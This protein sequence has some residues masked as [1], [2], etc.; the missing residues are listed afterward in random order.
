MMKFHINVLLDGMK[1]CILTEAFKHKV[2]IFIYT[3]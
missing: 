2:V 1:R 3:N